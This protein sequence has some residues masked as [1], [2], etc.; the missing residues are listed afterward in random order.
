MPRRI[1]FPSR[2][3]LL[4]TALVIVAAAPAVAAAGSSEALIDKGAELLENGRFKK[5]VKVF[6][7]LDRLEE[8]ESVTAK[9]GLARAWNGIGDFERAAESARAGVALATAPDETALAHAE[10]GFA[11]ARLGDHGADVEE[12]IAELRRFLGAHS[13]HTLAEPLRVR[14]CYIRAALPATQPLSLHAPP[15]FP[16]GQEPIDLETADDTVTPP[17]GIHALQPPWP[18]VDASIRRDH[19][20][21]SRSIIDADGCVHVLESKAPE[22]LDAEQITATEETLSTW[23]FEPARVGMEPVAVYKYLAVNF[24]R[25]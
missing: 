11:L 12:A 2:L 19:L 3:A 13:G 18:D 16:P 8:S 14:L 4:L 25:E 9:L 20:V 5:A 15:S 7:E 21:L 22:S 23:V 24:K 6:S 17:R 1:S 10:L